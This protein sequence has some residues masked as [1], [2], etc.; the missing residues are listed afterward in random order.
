MLD[1][2]GAD[3]CVA[4]QPQQLDA[5]RVHSRTDLADPAHHLEAAGGRVLLERPVGPPGRFWSC[6]EARV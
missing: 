2:D 4:Q 1:D 5:V 6:E 3:V